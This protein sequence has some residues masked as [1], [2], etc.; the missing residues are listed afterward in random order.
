MDAYLFDTCFLS[1]LLDPART[2]HMDAKLVAD[3]LP[4]ESPTFLSVVALAELGFGAELIRA[5]KGTVP[6]TIQHTIDAAR[7]RPLLDVTRHTARTY[8]EL[9]ARLAVH[10]L[11][12]TNRKHRPRWVEDW[13]DKNSAKALQIDENDLWMCA[14][15]LERNLVFVT[16][17]D[18]ISRIKDAENSLRLQIV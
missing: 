8:G 15:A 10:Y 11:A 2:K 5:M 3:S 6:P 1:A 9:K 14:Q 13:V 18:R 16:T 7:L 12:K 4:S 17:D